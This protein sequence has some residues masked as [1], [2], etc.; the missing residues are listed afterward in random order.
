MNKELFRIEHRLWQKAT[1]AEQ[2]FVYANR[3]HFPKNKSME[4]ERE[5]LYFLR[6]FFYK[7]KREGF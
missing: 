5:L 7:P 3:L 4:I 6:E 2:D 1:I